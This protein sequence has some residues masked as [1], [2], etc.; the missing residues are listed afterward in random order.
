MLV[1][2]RGREGGREKGKE[3]ERERE[4]REREQAK[5]LQRLGLSLAVSDP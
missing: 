3:R 4:G 5:S 2:G 1:C